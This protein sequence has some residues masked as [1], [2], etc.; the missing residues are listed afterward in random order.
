LQLPLLESYGLTFDAWLVMAGLMLVQLSV[1]DVLGIR[2]RHAPG[3]PVPF[4]PASPLFR[5]VRALGNT[6]ESIAIFV[7]G[8]LAC[9]G[10]GADPGATA[11][12]AWSFTA[13]RAGH[14]ACYWA[15]IGLARS[16][17]FAG[18]LLSLFA[19]LGVALWTAGV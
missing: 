5:A 14:A 15:G 2:R 8:T 7:L 11:A 13:F 16:L 19:L 4:D 17:C 1:A 6:N 10:R 18:A 3:A 9:V 12:A